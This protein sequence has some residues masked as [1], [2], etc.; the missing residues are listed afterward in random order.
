MNTQGMND[1]DIAAEFE[2][3]KAQLRELNHKLMSCHDA[4]VERA[5]NR[6]LE[7][8]EICPPEVKLKAL[9]DAQK[10]VLEKH[11]GFDH[12]R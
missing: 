4:L 6:I 11:P 12:S 10:A 8:I 2:S 5:L 9:E 3:C 1:G 7:S